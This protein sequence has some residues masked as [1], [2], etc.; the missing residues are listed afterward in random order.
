[1]DYAAPFDREVILVQNKAEK[2]PLKSFKEEIRATIDVERLVTETKV[3]LDVPETS[4]H[5]ILEVGLL[6]VR[7][8]R[9]Y[10]KEENAFS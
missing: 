1:M 2:I 3:I 8:I 7:L 10:G 5:R 9:V 4:V 6:K